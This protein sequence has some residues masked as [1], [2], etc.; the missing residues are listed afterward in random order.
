MQTPKMK[1]LKRYVRRGLDV[2]NI[3]KHQIEPLIRILMRKGVYQNMRSKKE[4]RYLSLLVKRSK[5][6]LMEVDAEHRLRLIKMAQKE[7][8][9]ELEELKKQGISLNTIR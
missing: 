9:E 5:L 2:S 4:R 6:G 1:L 8:A 7:V 3:L